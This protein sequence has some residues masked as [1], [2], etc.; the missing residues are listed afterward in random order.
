MR[1]LFINLGD[2]ASGIPLGILYL[3]VH[4]L[5][6]YE[7]ISYHVRRTSVIILEEH[8]LLS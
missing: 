3:E 8:H 4:P 6:S 7:N 1:P 2:K 5:S